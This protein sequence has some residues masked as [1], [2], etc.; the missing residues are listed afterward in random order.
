[1]VPKVC[2]STSSSISIACELLECRF[3]SPTL[4]LCIRDS[5]MGQQAELFNPQMLWMH[6][7][8][9]EAWF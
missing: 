2:F 9:Y 7:E 1:M 8:V 3:L 5:G 4:D 6:T